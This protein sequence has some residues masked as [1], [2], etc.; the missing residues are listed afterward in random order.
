M[1]LISH[2]QSNPTTGARDLD[3]VIRAFCHFGLRIGSETGLSTVR[4][5]GLNPRTYVFAHLM[6]YQ[7][8]NLEL[9]GPTVKENLLENEANTENHSGVWA[10]AFSHI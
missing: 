9:L 6:S 5:M 2:L 1:A 4:T 10:F 7:A 8:T 3:Q